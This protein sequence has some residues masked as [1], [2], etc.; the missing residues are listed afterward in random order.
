MR[1]NIKSKKF[2]KGF[3]LFTFMAFCLAAFAPAFAV[4][5][6]AP[7]KAPAAT[8]RPVFDEKGAFGFC[9][10]EHKE[11]D[12]LKLI[13]AMSPMDEINLDITI[14]GGGFTKGEQYD[15]TLGLDRALKKTGKAK[16]Y[17]RTVRAMALDG[18]GL[19]FQMGKSASFQK[20]LTLSR[21]L[22]VGAG[23]KTVTFT[24]P[25]MNATLDALRNC[26]RAT[27]KGKDHS[28]AQSGETA[29]PGKEMPPKL[30]TLLATAGFKDVI[31][32]NMDNVPQDE[33]PSDYLWQTGHL[34][35]G[36]RERL[37]PQDKSFTALTGLYLD[38]LKKKCSGTF[39][40]TVGR[41]TRYGGLRLL[42]ADITCRDKAQKASKEN[43]VKKGDI[44]ASLLF[45]LTDAGRFTVFTHEGLAEHAKE[46]TAAREAIRKIIVDL[47]SEDEAKKN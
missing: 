36:I 32:L 44:A 20:A 45:Y 33:R 4:G 28:P 31:P 24:L 13:V 43:H 23:G 7:A 8:I 25:N 6:K 16:P 42:P 30:R 18:N 38:G 40:A 39:K 29:T 15:L 3:I 22:T 11:K 46:A 14:P 35:G 1:K 5:E 37:A 26:N 12:G 19:L 34:L 41:E 47:A 2:S 17:T 10:A 27:L 21:T 9:L